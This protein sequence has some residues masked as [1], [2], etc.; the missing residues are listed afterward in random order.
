MTTL[1]HCAVCPRPDRL[2][3]ERVPIDN[4]GANELFED[5]PRNAGGD[6][7]LRLS[8]AHDSRVRLKSHKG[9]FVMVRVDRRERRLV[10]EVVA[11]II[12]GWPRFTCSVR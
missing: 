1:S 7:R 10:Y 2:D 8:P 12:Y 6:R 11:E 4:K 3:V 9:R 5:G